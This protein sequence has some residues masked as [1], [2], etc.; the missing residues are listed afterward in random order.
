MSY[1]KVP[2]LG[3]YDE[4]LQYAGELFYDFEADS[5]GMYNVR[6]NLCQGKF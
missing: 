2:V 4:I 3:I 5:D 1:H 6:E